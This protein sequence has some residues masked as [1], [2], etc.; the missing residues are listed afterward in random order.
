MLVACQVSILLALAG[1]AYPLVMKPLYVGLA[2][3]AYPIGLVVGELVMLAVYFGLITPIA[4]VFR[5][6]R[7]DALERKIDRDAQTYWRV[8]R[9]PDS[10][11]SYLRRW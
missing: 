7:R 6:T 11:T 1:W 5:F 2:L 3:L 10:V 4:L 8:K 9:Q